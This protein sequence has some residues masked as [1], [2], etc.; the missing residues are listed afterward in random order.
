MISSDIDKI[1]LPPGLVDRIA[2]FGEGEPPERFS[3]PVFLFYFQLQQFDGDRRYTEEYVEFGQLQTV[4]GQ[5]Y[6]CGAIL[7]H[8][9]PERGIELMH[10]SLGRDRGDSVMLFVVF[11]RKAMARVE[12]YRRATGRLPDSIPLMQYIT[13]FS[14]GGLDILDGPD[15]TKIEARQRTPLEDAEAF[16]VM[17]FNE[18]IAFA[19]TH[20]V[21]WEQAMIA[22]D[23]AHR[24]LSA[25]SDVQLP[26]MEALRAMTVELSRTWAT[27]FRPDLLRLIPESPETRLTDGLAVANKGRA[28]QHQTVA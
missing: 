5:L 18:G 12:A 6:Q 23:A 28:A 4:L 3:L 7:G 25:Y 8:I 14:E 11:K 27:M 2:T 26:D 21:L 9:Q 1:G 24:Q 16:A 22:H 10:L 19:I 15:G 20:T 17:A 13:S